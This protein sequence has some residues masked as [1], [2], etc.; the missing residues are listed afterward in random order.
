[1]LNRLAACLIEFADRPA[2]LTPGRPVTYADL[3]ALADQRARAL[4]QLDAGRVAYQLDNGTD[5]VVTNLALLLDRRTAIPIPSFF[6][7]AQRDHVLED[8]GADTFIGTEPPGTGWSEAADGIWQRSTC[9][10][11]LP[12]GTALI[13]YTSGTTGR[14]KGVC[15]DASTLLGTAHGIIERLSPLG[16]ERHMCVLPLSL[17]LENVAGLLANILNGGATVVAPLREVGL[18]GSS[19]IDLNR[20]VAAQIAAQPHSLILVPQLLLALTTAA[21]LG[22]E[23]PSSYRFI[24]VGGARVAPGLLARARA[25]G[26][27]VYEGYGLTECGSVVSLNVPGADRPGTAGRPLPHVTLDCLDGEVVVTG[28]VH[29]GYASEAALRQAEV[30]TGDIGHLDADGF[31][32]VQ[33]RLRHHYISAYGRNISPE[34]IESELTAE[35]SIGQAAVF[36]DGQPTNIALLVPRMNADHAAIGTAV[37]TCNRRLPDY[38]RIGA[39]QRV[40]P[41]HFATLGCLTDNGR[42]RRERVADAFSETIN[43]LYASLLEY[44]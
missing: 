8:S 43:Q 32:H 27:P 28:P 4:A 41:D 14:P 9:P 44:S 10:L 5:W 23:L 40:E 13:T 37:E 11:P 1:M 25:Q 17:L 39:W 3:A 15:L 36:G 18:T 6:S 38:A 33:G 22:L 20:F 21:E 31:L 29:L 42:V 26:L 19:G 35:L 30:R 7:A 2:L 16:I 34:W 12:A 24:A